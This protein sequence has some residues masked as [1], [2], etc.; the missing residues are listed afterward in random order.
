MPSSVLVGCFERTV[1]VKVEGR[2]TFQNSAGLKEFVK[3]M[4]QRGYRD[5]VVDLGECELMDST[6]MGTLAGVAL[7]LRELGQGSLRAVNANERNADLLSNL[8]LDQLFDVEPLGEK[9]M[10]APKSEDLV[11][12]APPKDASLDQKEVV[13]EAHEALVEADS[14]NAAKF[15]DVL[16]Y[17]RQEL[18]AK[19]DNE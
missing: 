15:R 14:A 9:G 3:Q 2:G 11:R 17:L 7:R 12:A 13:L 1:W 5:F 6:F 19:T 4:I 18:G 8:G 10:V 16:E